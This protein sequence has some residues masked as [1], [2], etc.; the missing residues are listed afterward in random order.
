MFLFSVFALSVFL[1]VQKTQAQKQFGP[2]F[3][4]EL[5]WRGSSIIAENGER[6]ELRADEWIELYN[7]SDEIVDISGWLI[8]DEAKGET[9]VE[10]EK[11]QI[12]PKSYF[13]IAHN[14]KDHLFLRGESVLNITPDI[15]SSDVSLSN[16]NLKLSLWRDYS[17]KEPV[18]VVGNGKAPFFGEYCPYEIDG[19]KCDV[20]ERAKSI[21]SMNRIDYMKEGSSTEAWQVTSERDNLDSFEPDPSR[22]YPLDYAT[23]QNSGKPKITDFGLSS[24]IFF[25]GKQ[26]KYLVTYTID[27][28]KDDLEK[29]SLQIYNGQEVVDPI[30]IS[31]TGSKI[32]LNYNFCPKIILTAEDKTGLIDKAELNIKCVFLNDKLIINEIMPHPK[33][34]D[35]DRDGKVGSTDEWIE[36]YNGAK[37]DTD[38]SGWKIKDKSQ[39]EFLFDG[40]IIKAKSY[41]V[42][43]KSMTKIS[44]NDNGDTI[45]LIDPLGKQID[46]ANIPKS[47]NRIDISYIRFGSKWSWSKTATLG[48]NNILVPIEEKT[49]DDKD[50]ASKPTISS[51]KSK[52]K[53]TQAESNK[54]VESEVKQ[55]IITTTTIRRSTPA[56]LASSQIAPIVL[57]SRVRRNNTSGAFIRF[58]YLL[59]FFGFITFILLVFCYEICRRE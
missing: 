16:S 28:S 6:F 56:V 7:D 53:S 48:K 57:G 47:T 36:I 11:G 49:E 20:A 42:L 59:Y 40:L 44:I 50:Q 27:D 17:D 1:P 45:Y 4:N 39:K 10:I 29:V 30:E 41:L 43:Y 51:T 22:K 12:A 46:V 8:F 13:L 19:Q 15:I 32:E 14:D 5:M 35:W 21:A 38:L 58:E 31:Q 52:T 9:M 24:D 55:T 18:D 25:Q 2:V 37:E 54:G 34:I 33:Q 3:F 26:N 23:P